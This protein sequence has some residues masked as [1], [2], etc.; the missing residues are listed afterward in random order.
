MLPGRIEDLPLFAAGERMDPP[1]SVP[2][3]KQD[4]RKPTNAPSP[5]DDPPAV[6]VVLNGFV[7]TLSQIST[8]LKA[9]SNPQLSLLSTDLSNSPIKITTCLQ[10]HQALRLR[11][12]SMEH[13]P[14]VLKNLQ[15]MAILAARPAHPRHKTRIVIQI[16]DTHMFL[17]AD[18]YAVQR[19]EGLAVLFEIRVEIGGAGE[20]ALGEQFRY[21]VHLEAWSIGR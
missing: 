14:R 4:P 7:V 17:H 11:R 21:A 20:G 5:P 1:I 16:L 3:P 10:M 19:T 2:I 13:R 18:G 8:A 9:P 12:P 15:N 6:K